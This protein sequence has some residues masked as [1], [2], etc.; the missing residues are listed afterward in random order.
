MIS[1]YA[2]QYGYAEAARV[3]KCSTGT[4][5]SIVKRNGSGDQT[6]PAE[7]TAPSAQQ[8]QDTREAS[9]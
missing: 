5:F 4:V 3:W 9:A 1:E 8:D 2:A 6:E 7:M